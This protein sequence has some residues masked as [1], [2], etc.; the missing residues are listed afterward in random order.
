MARIPQLD[1][2]FGKL[3]ALAESSTHEAERASARRRAE[4]VL[5]PG[6][7]GFDRALRILAY[8]RARASAPNNMFAGFDEFQEIDNPGHM[9]Q[10]QAERADKRRRHDAQRADLEAEFGSLDEVIEPCQRERF[11]VVAVKRWR[12]ACK[13]PHQRWTST[14]AGLGLY[15]DDKAPAE[16]IAALEG[17]YPMPATYAEAKAEAQ[18]WDRR[19]HD[20]ELAQNNDCGDYGLDQ[21]AVWRWRRVR[22]LVE[23]G[24]QLTTLPDIIDRMRA[25]RWNE[26]GTNTDIEDA[27][28]RD[29]E[30]LATREGQA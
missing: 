10:Q 22:D 21:V 3:V 18:Y 25:Y 17:A 11:L 28:L 4:A 19:N 7:G 2:R 27:L 16:V 24:M 6:V 12:K 9:A 26:G 1:P 13:P 29:L 14:I 20:M 30:A 23:H 15:D 8:E 5:T